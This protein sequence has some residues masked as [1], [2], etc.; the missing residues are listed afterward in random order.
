MVSW[1]SSV[2][3]S[4]AATGELEETSFAAV[5]ELEEELLRALSTQ[6][7]TSTLVGLECD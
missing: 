7:E 5:G 6:S 2:V 1:A 4:F 3:A